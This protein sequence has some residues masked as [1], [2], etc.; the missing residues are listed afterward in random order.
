ML[1]KGFVA[2]LR[3]RFTDAKAGD[4]RRFIDPHYLKEHGLQ[5]GPFP[6]QRVVTG[7]ICSNHL[8]DDPRTALIVAETEGGAKECFLFRLTVREGKVYIAPIS[9]PDKKTKS[10]NPWILRV[11]V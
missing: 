5:E 3:E 11:K 6:I 10:F 7:A 4:L 9:P 8:S 2:T 1:V